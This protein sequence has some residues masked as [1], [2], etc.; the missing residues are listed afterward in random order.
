MYEYDKLLLISVG[1]VSVGVE[2]ECGDPAGSNGGPSRTTTTELSLSLFELK[3]DC[4][5]CVSVCVYDHLELITIT[6]QVTS[7]KGG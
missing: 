7:S 2:I 4:I 5:M 3:I 1:G 6:K